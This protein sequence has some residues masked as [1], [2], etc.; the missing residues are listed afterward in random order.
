MG[1]VLGW[2]SELIAV[3]HGESVANAAFALAERE[4]RLNANVF[5]RD[6]DVQLTDLGR[7]QSAKLG[8]RLAE[9]PPAAIWCSPF[10][11]A[12]QSLEAALPDAVVVR[13]DER[14]RDREQGI[15]E[16]LTQR[17]IITS[18]PAE[19]ERR[20]RMGDFYYRPPGGESMPDVIS[21]VRAAVREIRDEH[22]GERVVIIAH[23][24]VVLAL[25]YLLEGLDEAGLR[26]VMRQGPVRNASI[27]S[28]APPTRGQR[29]MRLM[30]Y[31]ETA[32]LGSEGG[33][34][35]PVA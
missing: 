34:A 26:E 18:Y 16:F 24:A 14:L 3:R 17:A 5:G 32:H 13:F 2:P 33:G 25:R 19:A 9:D 1:A 7:E 10:V 35:G 11:R 20:G 8:A 28:W 6:A 31:N 15:L 4:G 21:R 12:R 27:T 29:T 30:I 23:D 22:A